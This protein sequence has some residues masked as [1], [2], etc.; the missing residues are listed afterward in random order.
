MA[1]IKQRDCSFDVLKGILILLVV[2][3]HT[4][5][6]VSTYNQ[7][8]YWH[9]HAFNSVYLFHMPLFVFVSGY[10]TRS[11]S[12]KSVKELLTQKTT[13]LILPW[14]IWSS[15]DL[16]LKISTGNIHLVGLG[17][18]L[19]TLYYQYCRI[20]YLPCIFVL[21]MMYYPIL[22]WYNS[23]EHKWAVTSAILIILW[24]VSL[25]FSDR[26]PFTALGVLQISRQ[27]LVFGMGL[28][29]Y[30]IRQNLKIAHITALMTLALVGIV[31]NFM[32]NGIWFGDFTL[33][34]KIFNG[35]CFTI[36]M[37]SV[38]YPLSGYLSKKTICH[39]IIWLGKNSLAIYVIHMICRTVGKCLDIYP[40][41]NSL[42]GY[43]VVTV[44]Y[45]SISIIITL[46]IKT[47]FKKRSYILGV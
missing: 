43:L 13:R 7:V 9:L 2:F 38:L 33:V 15:V 20:W 46:L 35:L 34:Q 3:G 5:Q 8:D 37:F 16:I 32:N 24:I 41:G 4:I 47:I 44:V 1:D 26:Q 36:V 12:N 23:G 45:L 18:S 11:I 25:A 28:L 39:P 22:K 31:V 29:Y 6:D 14:L 19:S 30:F 17:S 40:E 10:F 42:V 21:T 27:F